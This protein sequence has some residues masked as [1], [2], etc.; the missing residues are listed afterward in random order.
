MKVTLVAGSVKVSSLKGNK[1]LSPGEQAQVKVDG[2]QVMAA[3]TSEAVAW[4]NNEFKFVNTPIDIIMRQVKRWYDAEV[5]F[6]SKTDYHFNA[7]IDRTEPV[8]KL[9]HYLEKTGNVHF[10]IE[11]RKIIVMK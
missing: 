9:L 4:K 5:V 6:E 10:K 3:D 7:T 11:G 2:I 1:V 8:T